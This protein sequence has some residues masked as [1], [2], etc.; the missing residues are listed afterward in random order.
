M[1]FFFSELWA[2]RSRHFLN[3]IS[4]SLSFLLIMTLDYTARKTEETFED[5]VASNGLDISMIISDKPIDEKGLV[6]AFASVYGDYQII[7]A[8]EGFYRLFDL[9][10]DLEAESIFDERVTV[11]DDVFRDCLFNL[12]LNGMVLKVTDVLAEDFENIYF[13]AAKSIILP[14]KYLFLFPD[15]QKR[16]FLNNALKKSMEDKGYEV[17]SLQQSESA[18]KKSAETIRGFLILLSLTG[19]AAALVSFMSHS[20]SV[21]KVREREIGIKKAFGASDKDIF[22]EQLAETSILVLVSFVASSFVLNLILVKSG[23]E[24]EPVIPGSLSVISAVITAAFCGIF[25]ALKAAKTGISDAI[26]NGV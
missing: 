14:L 1:A 12:N 15:A 10:Y 23:M 21:I 16:Y 8:E 5:F 11:G 7:L 13:D 4:L 18:L 2:L 22:I 6:K 20:L 19:F 25:P 24:K 3:V 17:I 26:R 9:K